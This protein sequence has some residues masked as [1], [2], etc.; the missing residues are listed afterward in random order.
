[1]KQAKKTLSS[2]PDAS[3]KGAGLAYVD[4]SRPGLRR[5]RVGKGFQYLDVKGKVIKDNKT[6]SRIKSLVIPPAWTKVWVC[7]SANGHL[8]ATGRDVKGRK[9]YRYH[10]AWRE[11]RDETK[12]NKLIAFGKVLPQIRAKASMDLGLPGLPRSKVLAAVVFLLE[13]TL[14]RVGNEEYA[15][16]ND[17]FG[18]TTMRDQ[19]V[20]IKGSSMR[21]SFRGKSGVKH[22]IDLND[23]RLAKVVARCQAVPGQELFQYLDD[24]GQRHTISSHDVNTYLKELS[25]DDFTA[26]DFRTWAGTIMAAQA[27]KQFE[28]FDSQAQAKRHVVKAIEDVAK[29]LGNTKAV[30]RKC[31]IHPAVLD[32]YLSGSLV[33]TLS[34]KVQKEL[35]TKLHDLSPEEAAVLAFL[36]W[37]LNSQNKAA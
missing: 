11:A 22:A 25:G 31:Y 23:R 8:Q 33:E 3:A 6:I 32:A 37:H 13:G 2:S 24:A 7:P 35:R 36:Q 34:R 20:K 1:M 15:R 14:I 16:N 9:Q 17:S 26:K 28:A 5:R 27:L 19:H 29:R 21:F 10:P 18:L 12:Y 4:D 30:C